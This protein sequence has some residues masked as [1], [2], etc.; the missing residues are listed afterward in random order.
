MECFGSAI[1][2]GELAARISA[3]VGGGPLKTT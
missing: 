2:Q 3:V 1:V